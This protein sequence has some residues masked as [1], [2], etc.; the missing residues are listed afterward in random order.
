MNNRTRLVTPMF[1]LALTQ[2]SC[3]SA[4]TV[5]RDSPE[6]AVPFF[7]SEPCHSVREVL[8]PALLDLGFKI[9]SVE[10]ADV[11]DR[12]VVARKSMS[13]F[14]WGEFVRVSLREED[15]QT[16]RLEV[17]TKRRLATNVTAKGDWSSEIHEA[18]LR[19]LE[20]AK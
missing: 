15:A 10:D 18:V 16:S 12:T 9:E 8:E 14:S 13:A 2:T 7:V 20:T 4:A 11:C 3:A 5:A 17:T 19:N 6:S 1:L